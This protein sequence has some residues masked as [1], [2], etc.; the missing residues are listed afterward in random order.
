MGVAIDLTP[1]PPGA[2]AEGSER[3]GRGRG[4]SKTGRKGLRITAPDDRESLQEPLLRGKAAGG[5]ALKA[6]RPEG[7]GPLGGTRERRPRIVLR[8]AGGFGTT[9]LLNG[10]LS[11]GSPVVA[12]RSHRS[13]GRALR[14]QLGPW[15]PTASPGRE[16]AEVLRPPRF[17]RPPRQWGMRTPKAQGGSPEAVLGTTLPDLAPL[18]GA[19]ADE[20]RAGIAASFCQDKQG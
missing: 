3:T 16:L 5:P 17:C 11:R 1:L 4:R 15:P 20:G 19:E 7:E 10:R 2:K 14:P 8:L 12:K 9:A 18:A 6:A 13:R